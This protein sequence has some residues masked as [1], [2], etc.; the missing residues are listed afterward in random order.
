MNKRILNRAFYYYSDT[1]YHLT[2]AGLEQCDSKK[3]PKMLILARH[4]YLEKVQSFPIVNRKDLK[5]AIS[6]ETAD[7]LNDFYVFHKVLKTENGSTQ[8]VLWQI[9]KNI[10]PNSVVLVIPETLLLQA[11]LGQSEIL[12]FAALQKNTTTVIAKTNH[13]FHS[14]CQTNADV[15]AF[16]MSLGIQAVN[17]DK[18]VTANIHE[19]L[20]NGLKQHLLSAL[21]HFLIIKT[22]DTQEF[23]KQAKKFVLPSLATFFVYLLMS[24]AYVSFKHSRVSQAVNAQQD[25]IAQ[26][27]TLQN[28]LAELR[29]QYQSY[30]TLHQQKQPVWQIWTVLH[31]LFERGVQFQFIRFTGEFVFIKARYK[32]ASEVLEY[33]YDI[34]TISEATYT[35]SVKKEGAFDVFIIKFKLTSSEESQ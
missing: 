25:E 29:E 6:F 27:L 28:E 1:L 22:F 21:T 34:N 24:S 18:L 11:S 19:H 8:V 26:V 3:S 17:I 14:I 9:P 31:N 13:A 33:L 20:I 2:S 4:H 35:T 12:T 16:A 10:V 5:A 23:I 32:S 15:D 7:M 30:N